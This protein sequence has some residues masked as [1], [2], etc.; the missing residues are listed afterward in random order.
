MVVL[1]ILFNF[2]SLFMQGGKASQL[3]ATPLS[4]GCVFL[5]LLFDSLNP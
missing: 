4:F 3:I 1:L 5:I 2:S